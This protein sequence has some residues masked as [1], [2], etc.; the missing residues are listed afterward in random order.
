MGII[1]GH[2]SLLVGGIISIMLLFARYLL[3]SHL[4]A[5]QMFFQF[6]YYY[7]I[8]VVLTIIAFILIP[9]D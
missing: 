3:Y 1:I 4:S 6:K 2:V 8:I 7:I 9:I 5:K